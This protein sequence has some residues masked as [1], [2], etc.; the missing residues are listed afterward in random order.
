[1]SERDRELK[2]LLNQGYS[3]K[4]FTA[5]VEKGPNGQL[6]TVTF[7]VFS[8]KVFAGTRRFY[9]TLNNRCIKIKTR[10]ASREE[11]KTLKY[12]DPME[13]SLSCHLITN[14]LNFW[15]MSFAYEVLT[16]YQ[17]LRTSEQFKEVAGNRYTDLFAPLIAILR[18]FKDPF[19]VE[20]DILAYLSAFK[21]DSEIGMYT[22]TDYD[23]LR[24]LDQWHHKCYVKDEDTSYPHEGVHSC[25]EFEMIIE[26]RSMGRYIKEA[27]LKENLSA[28][29]VSSTNGLVGRLAKLSVAKRGSIKKPEDVEAMRACGYRFYQGDK[30][31]YEVI[32]VNMAEV[33][34]LLT[35]LEMKELD[36][37]ECEINLPE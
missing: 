35:M 21:A 7:Q 18:T 9:D 19:D 20:K 30:P 33:T 36:R 16:H 6:S 26:K 28:L 17:F 37:D 14:K 24:I 22:S 8:P 12:R 29:D 27:Y 3:K 25:T 4:G 15:S 23:I 1:L 13:E 5:R 2:P 34:N 31:M 11:R 10:P 32:K